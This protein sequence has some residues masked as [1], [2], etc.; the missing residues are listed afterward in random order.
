MSNG[1]RQQFYL[2]NFL[3]YTLINFLEGSEF[4]GM[5]AMLVKCMHEHL[6]NADDVVMLA[7]S[8]DA[9]RKM[10]SMCKTYAA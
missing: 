9:L 7:P 2:P 1:D 5:D 4:L 6:D 10:V 3:P 8:L